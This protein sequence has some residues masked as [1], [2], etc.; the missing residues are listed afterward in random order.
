MCA[1]QPPRSTRHGRRL[2]GQLLS[3]GA[4]TL[5]LGREGLMVSAPLKPH[6]YGS[7]NVNTY[8]QLFISQLL[9]FSGSAHHKLVNLA[10]Q[11][12]SDQSQRA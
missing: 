12:A 1:C 4:D 2:V 3:K 7:I 5:R 10:F 11:T 8:L 6:P 9:M